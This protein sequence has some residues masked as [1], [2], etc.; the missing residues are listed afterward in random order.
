MIETIKRTT[1]IFIDH[2]VSTS[3]V[4]QILLIFSNIDKLNLNLIKVFGYL[5]Q[6]DLNVRYKFEN[7]SIVFDV[8]FKLSTIDNSSKAFRKKFF[9]N[10]F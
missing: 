1:V 5:S 6:F 7:I 9:L 2:F 4:R 3:I 10:A 8:L